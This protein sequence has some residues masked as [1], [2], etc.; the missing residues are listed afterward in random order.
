MQEIC[1]TVLE[2]RA[3]LTAYFK[4]NDVKPIYGKLWG[5]SLKGGDTHIL[6]IRGWGYFTGGGHGA[7]GLTEE[8]GSQA[9]KEVSEYVA[10]AWNAAPKLAQA[11]HAVDEALT[12]AIKMLD[13]LG[14]DTKVLKLRQTA[15]L[16]PKKFVPATYKG[17][18]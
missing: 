3:K 14:A 2:G 16:G 15:A 6:D 12:D 17:F 18:D 4:N 8:Q 7:L 5:G 13:G 11:Y 1:K 10:N 9:F